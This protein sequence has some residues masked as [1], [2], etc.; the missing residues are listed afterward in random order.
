M[1][2]QRKF[3][4]LLVL[5][6]LTVAANLGAAVW[7]VNMLD[8][9]QR[10]PIEG[11]TRVLSG[12]S[13][14][15]RSLWDQAEMLDLPV[16]EGRES[17][18]ENA[19]PDP[20]GTLQRFEASID[21]VQREIDLLESGGSYV[22]R[23]GIST[24]RNLRARIELTADEVAKWLGQR[25]D[26]ARGRARRNLYELH[27]LIERIEGRLLADARIAAEYG[28]DLRR[29][30]SF[31]LGASLVVVVLSA[32]LAV[33]LF[34]RWVLRPVGLLRVAADEIA[35]GNFEHRVPELARDELGLLSREVNDMAQTISRMQSERIERE[36]LAA[37]GEMAQSVA[38]NIRNPLGGIRALAELSA[39]ELP[40]DSPIRE[41]Q[42][43]IVRTVDRFTA[44]LNGLLHATTP[45]ELHPVEGEVAAW[46]EG[47]VETHRAS[48]Q[49][50][51]VRL[52][53]DAGAAPGGAV[54]DRRHLEQAVVALLTNAIEASRAG[55]RVQVR[56]FSDDSWWG[57][58]VEDEG[59]GVP[60]ELR[61]RV[62]AP[63]FTTKPEGSGIGLASVRRVV[64]Q[65]GGRV[66][67]ENR[68]DGS[69]A[70]G[71]TGPGAVFTLRLPL[72]VAAGTAS[73]GQTGPRHGESADH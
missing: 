22:V 44:W 25:D 45:L 1:T 49:S 46:L 14:L 62:F 23:S 59:G 58:V 21:R 65:H 43:R 39:D 67:V 66:W 2:L 6:G 53:L 47:I 70:A 33:V 71:W 10:E 72:G 60:E 69:G 34:R 32:W 64:G 27:E 56:A 55:G 52:E 24:T 18:D 40:P 3:A 26:D 19:A 13:R 16:L 9:E 57:V 37:V 42:A 68:S 7:V 8:R 17:E 61:E 4:V 11:L 54:F 5:L 12:M 73:G 28:A 31:V 63:Y 51:G 38:H 30:L 48:A 20:N 36:R 50:R 41:N 15:K 29:R 35:R